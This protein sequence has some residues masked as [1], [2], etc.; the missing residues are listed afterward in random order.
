M[1]SDLS[2]SES[3][4]YVIKKIST[5]RQR[6]EMGSK[7]IKRDFKR[8]ACLEHTAI[9]RNCR[10]WVLRDCRGRTGHCLL[11]SPCAQAAARAGG[12]AEAVTGWGTLLVI[13]GEGAMLIRETGGRGSGS[14]R[15]MLVGPESTEDSLSSTTTARV[16]WWKRGRSVGWGGSAWCEANQGDIGGR[17]DEGWFRNQLLVDGPLLK[18]G[19]AGRTLG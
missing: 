14:R 4:G 3:G 9:D 18:H 6:Q 12:L 16:H 15:V 5:T 2:K 10:W 11:T 13:H 19:M 17:R 1:V 8:V 7:Y